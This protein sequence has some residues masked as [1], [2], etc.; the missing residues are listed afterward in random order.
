MVEEERHTKED[1]NTHLKKKLDNFVKIR[2]VRFLTKFKMKR[3]FSTS[4][5]ERGFRRTTS[6]HPSLNTAF[7]AGH[8]IRKVA[9]IKII[10]QMK[11]I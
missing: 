4:K 8:K 7:N 11:K 5:Q 2:M 1:V 6:N 3:H 10:L 9:Q